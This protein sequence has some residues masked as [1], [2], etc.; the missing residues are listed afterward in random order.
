MEGASINT[1]LDLDEKNCDVISMDV[2]K[3]CAVKGELFFSLF[4]VHNT[5]EIEGGNEKGDAAL[6]YVTKNKTALAYVGKIISYDEM[7]VRNS[8]F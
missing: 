8:K 6:A 4:D 7:Q 3:L 1:K 5:V 2:L